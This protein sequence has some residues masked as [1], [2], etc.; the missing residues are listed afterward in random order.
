MDTQKFVVGPLSVLCILALVMGTASAAAITATDSTSG[1]D[2]GPSH[3]PS[4]E[5]ILDALESKGVD[6]TQVRA[7]LQNGDTDAVKAW[8][9]NYFQSNKPAMPDGS[10]RSPPDLTDPTQQEKTI[11]RL[12]EQGVD[13]TEVRTEVQNGD[14]AAVTAW[15][16]NYVYAHEGEMPYCHPEE[17]SP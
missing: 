6:V 17:P 7:S 8:L 13:V 10:G 5:A 2:T 3:H 12:E 9:E 14:T 15:L 1:S 4:P 16:E 11:S